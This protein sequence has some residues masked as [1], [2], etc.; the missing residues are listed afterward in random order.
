MNDSNEVRE[1]NYEKLAEVAVR[2]P[3]SLTTRKERKSLLG[4][5]IVAIAVVKIGLVPTKISALGIEFSATDQKHI[6]HILAVIVI[7]YLVAFTFYALSDFISWRIAVA[8]ALHEEMNIPIPTRSID[9]T[10]DEVIALR[11]KMQ[12]MKEQLDSYHTDDLKRRLGRALFFRPNFAIRLSSMVS[13]GRIVI[14]FLIP[15]CVGIY[16]TW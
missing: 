9:E 10:P 11:A 3:L 12:S 16:A 15:I 1:M 13:L 14:E 8:A 5:G 2:D 7:Y 4:I 6:Y